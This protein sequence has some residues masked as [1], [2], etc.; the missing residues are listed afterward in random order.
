MILILIIHVLLKR[1]PLGFLTIYFSHF[2]IHIEY[3]KILKNLRQHFTNREW[4]RCQPAIQTLKKNLN[5]EKWIVK[6][7]F[8]FHIKMYV[9]YCCYILLVF[10]PPRTRGFKS[11]DCRFSITIL[12]LNITFWSFL[13]LLFCRPMCLK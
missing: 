13:F 7:E 10:K 3:T 6:H 5:M 11:A 2:L 8:V 4:F 1:L 12:F 9:T